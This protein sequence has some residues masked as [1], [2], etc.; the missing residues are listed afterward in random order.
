MKD[1]GYVY[2]NGTRALNQINLVV[3]K[4]EFVAIMGQ[5]GAGKTTLIRTLNGL[6]R[7]TSGKI[8]LNGKDISSRTVAN[9]SKT[10][11]IV[12]QNPMHQ[13]FSNTIEEEIK[14]SL[15][16]LDITKEQ[17]QV[18]TQ[19]ILSKFNLEKYKARSPF[20]LSGGEAK[21]LALACIICRNPEILI[22]DEPTLGQ[23]AKEI[24][25]IIDLIK[26]ERK[27]GKTII[28]VTHNIEF[29][30]EY[31]PR[32]IL[33]SNGHIITDGPTRKILINKNLV[34]KTS[35]ILPQI[36]QFKNYLKDIGINIPEN[37]Y[38]Q[39]EIVNFLNQYFELKKL[40]IMEEKT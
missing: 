34:S 15:K 25:F 32:T 7:P 30:L 35:L 18:R 11:G 27:A 23:D 33:M 4:G 12:F 26:S 9:L 36:F 21:K 14:F 5:N 19:A 31:I 2:P 3:N 1:V 37:L 10:V 39:K 6:L 28:I 22:F 8:F 38:K 17:I 24:K 13:L 40:N 16:N 20:N 29:S